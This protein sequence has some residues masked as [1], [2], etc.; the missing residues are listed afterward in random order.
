MIRSEK[1]PYPELDVVLEGHAGR[2]QQILG[3]KF[4][5]L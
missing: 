3:D 1:A 2:I 4:M 5:L